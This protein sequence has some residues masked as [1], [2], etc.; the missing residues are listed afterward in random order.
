MFLRHVHV[1]FPC[2]RVFCRSYSSLTLNCTPASCSV[3]VHADFC[4]S[5]EAPCSWMSPVYA[6]LQA[7]A[8]WLQVPAPRCTPAAGCCRSPCSSRRMSDS[9]DW[10]WDWELRV[11]G[12]SGGHW[13]QTLATAGGGARHRQAR[14]QR[15]PANRDNWMFWDRDVTNVIW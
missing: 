2:V 3:C 5:V 14:R 9:D 4:S 12:V 6:E 15:L 8:P 1:H 13:H 11:S 7:A 10:N